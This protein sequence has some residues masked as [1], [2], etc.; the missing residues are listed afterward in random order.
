MKAIAFGALAAAALLTGCA[1]T[2]NI[3]PQYVN[4]SNFQAYSCD[5]LQAEV[6]R[7]GALVKQTQ[8]QQ[9]GLSAS[10]IGIGITGGR[11]GIYPS[12]SFGVGAG[13]TQRAAKNNALAKLYGEHDAMIIAARQKSCA[14][15]AGVKIYGE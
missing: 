4:P 11:G 1:S 12:I 14:F 13:N 6:D 10:G 7:V 5:Q 3:A 9:V 8:K 2:G 15:A